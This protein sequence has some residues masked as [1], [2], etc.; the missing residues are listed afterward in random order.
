MKLNLSL[1]VTGSDIQSVLA[2]VYAFSPSYQF[3]YNSNTS[4]LE[5]I[6]DASQDLTPAQLSIVSN[7][8]YTVSFVLTS[9]AMPVTPVATPAMPVTAPLA[10][11]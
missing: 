8:K 2:A 4:A 9:P 10:T 7:A 6:I 3:A 5:T 11:S 1:P